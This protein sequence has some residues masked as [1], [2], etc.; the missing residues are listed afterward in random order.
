MLAPAV[1]ALRTPLLVTEAGDL[2]PWRV[3]T[4]RAVSEKSAAAVEGIVAAQMSFAYSMSRFWLEVAQGRSPSL[5]NGVAL[6]Q[7]VHAALRP[8]GSRVRQNYSRLKPRG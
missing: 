7:A 8:S 2:N 5:F 6:E 3:E 4:V 1:A